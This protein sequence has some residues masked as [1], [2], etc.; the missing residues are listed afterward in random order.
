[1]SI[2]LKQLSARLGLSVTTVS[3]ALNGYS[4]VSPATRERVQKL[5][6]ELGYR[7]NLAARRLARG[8][9]DAVGLVYPLEAGDLG[10]PRFLEVIEG[11]SDALEAA[12]MDLLLVS[13]R[14]QN[15]LRSYQR[16]IGG[17]HVDGL[18]VARTRVED[19]R[20]ALLRRE[21]T[22]FVA[23]GRSTGSEAFSWFDFDNQ[24]GAKLAVQQAV[25]LGHRRIAYLHAPLSL[26]FAAQRKAG[27]EAAMAQAGLEQPAELAV[28]A[29]LSRRGG[30]AAAL[31]LLALPAARRPTAILTDNNLCG[32]GV[33]RALL[34]RGVAI[35]Q[36]VSVIVYD[37]VPADNLL[38]G[39]TVAA[40]E[41]PTAY[42]AGQ[43][44]AEM[45]LAQIQ[46]PGGAPQQ[47]LRQPVFAAG[48]S[49]GPAP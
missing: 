44:M 48:S 31:Q 9:A 32:L 25:A 42:E 30:H 34:D 45:L 38:A 12:Q 4:D 28:E 19:E 20:I 7:A 21:A 40:I 43:T 10:D 29:G 41:Q 35:G 39:M 33:V 26:N 46:T 17:G 22:P 36:E 2:D 11:L 1:M 23:Y 47:V 3:R 6:Q 5:A 27:H 13:A 15:E 18:I 37:G 16:L 8:Q 49:L 24:A 14:A